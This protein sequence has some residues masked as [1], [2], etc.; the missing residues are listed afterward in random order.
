[1]MKKKIIYKKIL[2][3]LQMQNKKKIKE[4]RNE[5]YQLEN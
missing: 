5:K 2:L 3:Y 1:M 4:E